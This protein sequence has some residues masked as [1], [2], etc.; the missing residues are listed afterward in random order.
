M[1]HLETKKILFGFSDE[2]FEKTLSGLLRCVDYETEIYARTS[3]IAI[4][5]AL[6]KIPDMDAVV[7]TETLEGAG[8]QKRQKYS[9]E[10]LAALADE[11][12]ANVIVV[13]SENH[14]GTDYVRVLLEAGITGAIFVGAQKVV[15]AKEVATLIVR[16]RTKKDAR[17]YYGIGH[18][19]ADLGFLNLDEFNELYGRFRNR[20]GSVLENYLFICGNLGNP[21]QIA[22][23]TKRLPKDDL[24]NLAAFEEFHMVMHSLKELGY[25]L[26]IEKPRKV[27]SG[28]SRVPVISISNG[29]MVIEIPMAIQEDESEKK[30]EKK[31]GNKEKHSLFNREK[32]P[33]K[34]KNKEEK[35]RKEK[36]KSIEK[37]S[38]EKKPEE[39]IPEEKKPEEIIPEEKIVLS[40]REKE[41][42][43]VPEDK[44]GSEI[45]DYGEFG[46][47]S[48]DEML[49]LMS[50]ASKNQEAV[51]STEDK[52]NDTKE[53]VE[54]TVS[55]AAKEENKDVSATEYSDDTEETSVEL[56]K[57]WDEVDDMELRDMGRGKNILYAGVILVLIVMLGALWYFGGGGD[58][59][60]PWI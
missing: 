20:T 18:E 51:E 60:L 55:V 59:A 39:I 4:N 9:A 36:K 24:E 29:M 14:K 35:I 58:V 57:Y 19:K 6:K 34:E 13:L 27:S 52:T 41:E 1:I 53:P 17:E 32:K 15:T 11:S 33:A 7:L 40:V 42:S 31:N 2:K 22:D 28:L 44:T 25:D 56:P 46:G 3:K 8:L 48:I 5:D 38:E 49:A 21:K 43:V 26:Q 23:F 50:G 10:E 54:E 45:I 16:K 12:N 30:Q 37:V 47:M